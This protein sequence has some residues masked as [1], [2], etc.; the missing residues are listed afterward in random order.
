M[1]LSALQSVLKGVGDALA[2]FSDVSKG[3]SLGE[4]GEVIAVGKD[5]QAV[6]ASAANVV[7][8]WES[9]DDTSRAQLVAFISSNVKFPANTTAELYAQKVL[10][11]AVSLSAVFKA[12]NS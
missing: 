8:E 5:V 2:L 9:L 11:V 12:W 10:K 7:P 3:F 6:L 4:I 1:D